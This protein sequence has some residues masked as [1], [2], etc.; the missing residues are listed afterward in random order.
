MTLSSR[1]IDRFAEAA[2]ESAFS[3]KDAADPAH[4]IVIAHLSPSVDQ[5]RF[6]AKRVEGDT[7]TVEA[8]IFADGH[9]ALAAVVA[10]KREEEVTWRRVAMTALPNDR[11]RARIRLASRGRY[12]FFVEGWA[13]I[14]RGFARDLAKK[15]DAGRKLDVERHEGHVLIVEA[16]KRAAGDAAASLDA[17][18]RDLETASAD[19]GI[20]RLLAPETLQLMAALDERKFLTRGEAQTVEVERKAAGFASWYELFPRSQT[21]APKRHGTFRDV[22]ARLPAIRDMGFDVLYMPPIHP[23]G[24]THRKGR[25]N[26]LHAGPDDPGSTYAIG[27]AEG[28]HTAIHPELGTLADFHALVGAAAEQGI[29]IALDFAI[30]CSPDHPWL[31]EHP[32]WFN[33]R[34]DG[35]VKYAEN[36]PKTYEDIVNVDFYAPGALPGLWR[37]LRDVVVYWIEQGVRIFRVD[38]PHTKPLPF[39]QWMIADV[40]K[41]HPDVIFFSEAFTRPN[42][43]YHLA[44]VGFGQ[45]YTYFTWR[46]TK[47]ELTDYLTELTMTEVRDFYRPNFFVNTPDINPPFLQS[48]G[49]PAFLIRAAL[50]TTLSGLWGMYSG[51]ELCEADALP[52]RE[53]YKNSEKYEIKPRDWSQ[54]GNIAAE[55]AQLNALRKR[56]PALHSHLGVTF[57]NIFNDRML[58]YAK[59]APSRDDKLLIAVSLNP[60]DAEEGDFE[61]PLWEWQLPDDESVAV[62]DL[63][64]GR[65]FTWQGKVQ[66]LRLEPASP[67]RIWRIRPRE[68]ALP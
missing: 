32:E 49:R 47:R 50:A 33:W 26:S 51:F 17:I 2:F 29:E 38:N 27:S 43:M 62:E 13:D 52:G 21:D 20:E 64:Q 3:L 44:K 16:R 48:G 18:L 41:K 37:A 56:E 15:R 30:Q 14:Y 66:H 60:H 40:R 19:E 39:W 23:I 34:P 31:K 36:P 5:G 8:D 61:V 58:Y 28:G 24:T 7:L 10:I 57:Y 45:S 35:T 6:P 54:P 55:I 59:T 25:N 1:H 22:I 63:L 53:E 46:N 11:W 68:G 4:R 65:R 67:Y 9:E 12:A 42:M